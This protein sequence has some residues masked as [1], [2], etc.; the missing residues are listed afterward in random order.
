MIA[1]KCTFCVVFFFFFLLTN[2]SKLTVCTKH[3]MHEKC[4]L[5]SQ[6]VADTQRVLSRGV[7]SHRVGTAGDVLFPLNIGNKYLKTLLFYI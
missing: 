2:D 5:L 3:V 4:V 1:N 6:Q 7:G